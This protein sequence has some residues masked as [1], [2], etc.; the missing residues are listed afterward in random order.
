MSNLLIVESPG[1]VQKLKLLLGAGWK[2]AASV[3]HIRDLPE[4]RLGVD[5]NLEPQYTLTTRGKEVARNLKAL[6]AQ[7]DTVYLATDPDREGEAISWHLQQVLKPARYHRV[8]FHEITGKA[9]LAAIRNPR[10]IDLALVRAQEGRRVLDRLVGYQISPL[11]TRVLGEPASA[12]RVQSVALRLVVERE[13]EIRNFQAIEHYSAL[14]LFG[15]N[16]EWTAEWKLKP[17]FVSDNKP[18]FIDKTFAQKVAGL[19]RVKVVSAV[20]GQA[21]RSPPA[22]FITSTLQQA[23]SVVLHFDPKKTMSLAQHL[24]DSGFITYHRTDNPNLSEEAYNEILAYAK[25]FKL[26]V[27]DQQRKWRAKA[28]AQESHEACRPTHIA[29]KICGDTPDEETLYRLIRL[30]ALASQM[31]DA[32]YT[33]RQ[34]ELEALDPVQG[35]TIRFEAKGRTLIFPGWLQATQGDQTDEGDGEP[36]N[37]V[38]DLKPGA[39]LT[40]RDGKILT[41]KTKPPPRYT[42]ASLIKKLEAEEI[43]RPSTYASIMDTLL[44]R[45]YTSVSRQF[46]FATNLGER[47]CDALV[48]HFAFME[49]P[50]TRAMEAR[51]DAIAAGK[52]RYETVIQ[53]TQK[54]LTAEIV[55]IGGQGPKAAACPA[56]RSMNLYP[57]K[58][59]KGLSYWRCDSCQAAFADDHGKPGRQFGERE[60]VPLDPSAPR[61]PACKQ[62]HLVQAQSEGGRPYWRCTGYPKCNALFGDAHGQPGTPFGNQP[63]TK[64]ASSSGGSRKPKTRT[65]SKARSCSMKKGHTSSSNDLL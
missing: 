54:R 16:P 3:G 17:D 19:R 26:P 20:D 40:A 15:E 21:R 43:G 57:T 50:F 31:E 65:T 32:R 18:Y 10:Q 49:V 12:G 11:V 38:P 7:A 22:P 13:R 28:G 5:G 39:V 61:C 44:R 52:D 56:C 58:S 1:K 9:V 62:H 27:V 64:T 4:D 6:V 63:K 30:R 55:K 25:S 37:P 23:A 48:G 45:Q 53:E 2:V 60:D 14:L 59:K 35:R 51:L 24:Y 46:L 33:T 47:L 34:V 29:D 42:Q 41:K 36:D 8:T